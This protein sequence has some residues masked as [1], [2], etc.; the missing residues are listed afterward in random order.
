MIFETMGHYL[1]GILHAS[2]K[3]TLN[4]IISNRII[5]FLLLTVFM[6]LQC[7]VV[8]AQERTDTVKDIVNQYTA[9]NFSELRTLNL[10]WETMPSYDYTV[11]N[12]GSDCE[13]GR[14]Q[15]VDNLHFQSTFPICTLG[16]VAFAGNINMDYYHMKPLRDMSVYSPLFRADDAHHIYLKGNLALGY[17]TRLFGRPLM[18]SASVGADGWKH[19]AE[20]LQLSMVATMM[21]LQTRTNRLT[22]GLYAAYPYKYM[23]FIPMLIWTHQFDSN[24]MLDVTLPS[25]AYLRYQRGCHRFSAGLQMETEQLYMKAPSLYRGDDDGGNATYIFV[26]RYVKPELTYECILN[27]HFFFVARAGVSCQ[28][29]GGLYDRDLA[30]LGDEPYVEMSRSPVPFLNVGISYNLFK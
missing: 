24:W 9:R 25:R 27:N 13:G 18:M 11:T 28:L 30:G 22:A 29:K 4:D 21:V 3:E 17:H 23:P 10:R 14:M 15:D 7:R 2:V 6:A 20:Q 26:N 19:G 8:I 16:R 1:N 5:I 12:R